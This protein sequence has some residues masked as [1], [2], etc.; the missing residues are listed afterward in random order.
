M[1]PIYIPAYRLPHSKLAVVEKLIQEMLDQDVI[2]PSNSEWNFP[3]ILVPKS[4]GTKGQ[5]IDYRELNKQIIP[6]RLPLPVISDI[7]RSLG[8]E[9]KLF[10]TL[11]IKSAFWQIELQEDSKDMTAFSKPTGHYRYKR[12]PFGLSNSPL[13][14]MRLMNI[15]L[16][17]LIGNTANVFLDDI[18]IVSET[19]EH[20]KKP[21]LVFSR[22][23][24]AGLK[25]K[26]EK[27][28]FLQD[29]VIYLG[30][31]IDRHGLRTVQSKV[32]AVRNFPVPTSVEKVRSYLG[33]TGYYRQFIS[34][35]ADIAHPLTSLLKQ[36]AKFHWGPEQQNPFETLKVKLTSVPVLILPDYTREFILCTD[37][38][39]IGL[40]GILMQERNGKPQPITYASR[41]YTSAER[42]YSITERETLA[43]IYCLERFRDTIQG[44]KV[45]VWT[46]HTAI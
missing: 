11:D 40:G 36:D 39:D 24:G 17:G 14:Y 19:A 28:S 4:D 22:L 42:K 46:D 21:D 30:Y 16:H 23:V 3:L 38:S 29:K 25:V 43:V 5:V 18:L 41:L 15:A 6:D 20:F 7:L 8:T 37:A 12:M 33:L 44:Y 26:L 2:E 27:C 45:K 34:G 31:Q 10:T 9:N 35:Y 13:S 1:K 32:D